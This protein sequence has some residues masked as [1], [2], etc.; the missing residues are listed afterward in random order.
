MGDAFLVEEL[1]G[2]GDV[3]NHG[4]GFSFGKKLPLLN[5]VEKL[6]SQY[7]LE[8][9][10]ELVRFL[11]VLCELYDILVA[12]AVVESF[13]FLEDPGPGVALPAVQLNSINL[14]YQPYLVSN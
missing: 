6:T 13:N 5:V 12:L 8:N 9:K 10:V 11:E 3:L 2:R 1:Q 14:I 4:G 7:L